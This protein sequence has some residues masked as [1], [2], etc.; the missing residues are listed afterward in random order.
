MSSRALHTL[1][2]TRFQMARAM[3]SH[4]SAR[5]KRTYRL[6]VLWMFCSSLLE[7]ATFGIFV[8][9]IKIATDPGLLSTTSWGKTFQRMAGLSSP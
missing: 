8:S 4:L 7:L 5:Q 9:F 2:R 1:L 6:S 3:F